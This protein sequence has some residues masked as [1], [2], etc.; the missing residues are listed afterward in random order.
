MATSHNLGQN[1]TIPFEVRY[2]G[3]D[4]KMHYAR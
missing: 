2:L 4:G 3:P 1:F